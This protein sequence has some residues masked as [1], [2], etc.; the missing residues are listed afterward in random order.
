VCV[1]RDVYDPYSGLRL[2]AGRH[3]VEGRG[4]LAFLRS[5]HA[6]GQGREVTAVWV[7]ARGS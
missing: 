3:L 6:F 7:L 5:R 1:D 2:T 4:A